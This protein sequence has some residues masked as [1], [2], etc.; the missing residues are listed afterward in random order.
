[1]PSVSIPGDLQRLEREQTRGADRS[2][3]V[4]RQAN[5]HPH[6]VVRQARKMPQ[7]DDFPVRFRQ[8][9]KRRAHVPIALCPLQRHPGV[10][11]VRVFPGESFGRLPPSSVQALVPQNA[12][13][14]AEEPVLRI[15]GIQLLVDLDVLGR[16]P[17]VLAVPSIRTATVKRTRW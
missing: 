6:L 12:V 4:S 17:R 7:H 13:N 15:V 10:R 11:I 8:R 5:R 14:P 1:M 16:V 3:Q 9:Q 2:L